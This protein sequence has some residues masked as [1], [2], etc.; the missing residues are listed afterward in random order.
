[1]GAVLLI[2]TAFVVG[3]APR[4]PESVAHVRAYFTAIHEGRVAD[5]LA[6]AG[7]RRPSGD[8]AR[9]LT[10][11]ALTGGW[12]IVA[13]RE[14]AHYDGFSSDPEEATVEIAIRTGGT[15][16]VSALTLLKADG[17]WRIEDPLVEVTFPKTNM[18]YVDVNGVRAPTDLTADRSV[19][20][21]LPGGYRFYTDVPGVAKVASKLAP[22]LPS[23]ARV[24]LD[25]AP[26]VALTRKGEQA[27]RAALKTYLDAC[28]RSAE[29]TPKGCPFG[30]DRGIGPQGEEY[31]SVS[32][33][34]EVTWE[35]QRYPKVAVV[36]N[37]LRLADRQRGSV[38][39][40]VT[41]TEDESKKVRYSVTCEMRMNGYSLAIK[42]D[43]T[44]KV[45]SQY[46]RVADRD[47]D[48]GLRV[49]SCG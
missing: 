14:S 1:M 5:A 40:T 28:A 38:R 8:E 35:I 32:D 13:L 16:A 7:V 24:S 33:F 42:P 10:R 15:T 45:L 41:A 36:P 4:E 39:V 26:G 37:G 11:K 46:A 44:L 30:A 23:Q 18:L 31:R 43:G 29:L 48:Y 6:L 20:A 12:K 47:D 2:V 34:R 19:Y 25:L 9:F 3:G 27:A 17:E 21:L 49:T 22:V